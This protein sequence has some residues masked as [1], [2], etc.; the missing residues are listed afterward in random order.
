[1][2]VVIGRPEVYALLL[3]GALAVSVAVVS[4]G[5]ETA[6]KALWRRHGRQ[7]R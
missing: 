6:C 4:V 5:I 2:R 3:I 1:M 7:L